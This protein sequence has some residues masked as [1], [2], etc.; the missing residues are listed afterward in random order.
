MAEK[1][2][3]DERRRLRS[4]AEEVVAHGAKEAATADQP[5]SGLM[6]ELQVQQVE[7]EMQ[8]EAL[9]GAQAALEV[10][11]DRYQDLYDFAPVGYLTVGMGGLIEEANLTCA[12]ML[13]EVRSNVVGR[14]FAA[15]VAPEDSDRWELA[16]RSIME[17]GG[18]QICDVKL[19]RKDGSPF[20]AALD[21]LRA[22]GSA[23]PAVRIALVDNGERERT[24]KVLRQGEAR[25][26]AGIEAS[27]VPSALNDELGNITWLNK[28]FLQTIGFTLRDIPTVADWWPLAYPD[29]GYR[30]SVADSWRARLEKAR[31]TGTPFPPMELQINCKDGKVRDFVVSASGLEGDFTGNH[32]VTLYE[33]TERKLAEEQRVVQEKRMD[34]AAEFGGMGLWDLDLT[35]NLAWRTLQHDRLFGYDELQPSWGVEEALHHVVPEDRPIFQHALEEALTT[36]DFHYELRIDPKNHPRRWIQADG[37]VSRDDAGRPV[38]MAGTVLDITERKRLEQGLKTEMANA[39]AIFESSPVAM[40]VVDETTNIVRANAASISMMGVEVSDIVQHRPGNALRCV[41]SSKDPRGCGYSKEC[42]L[43]QARNGIEA[44]IAG[45]GSMHGVEL[46]LELIRDGEP[47]KVWMEFGAQ[48]VVM[49]GRR[50][51]CVSLSDLTGRKQAEAALLVAHAQLALTSRLAALGTLVAGVAHEINNP[52]AAALSDQELARGAVRE[53]RDHLRGSG[54]LDRETEVRRLDE[55]VE[56][57]DEA[58]EAGRRIERIVKDLKTFGR[59]DQTRTRVRLIDIV[60]LAMRWLPVT[61][62]QTATVTVE[63]GGAPD[64]TASPGQIEQVVVN[65]VTNAAKATPEGKRGAIVVRIGPGHPGMARLDVVDHGKGIEPVVMARIFDPFFTTRDVGKGSGLG[66]SIC[67]TIVANHGGTLTATS[68]IGKGSTFRV[69]LPV[70]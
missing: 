12:S 64:I 36:G 3:T 8:N 34:L 13:G 35:T 39:D 25:L 57:L 4:H 17:K 14:S 54:P 40:I 49:N 2:V 44:L 21:C 70:A 66:L 67:H 33:I 1:P 28:A 32:I 46:Q 41:H 68:E 45:G 42:L 61:I 69:E 62:G 48:Q 31:L 60:E 55:V 43:C 51:L 7:L 29:P 53:V 63:N 23:G 37:R 18:K 38:R 26:R 15:F 59:H 27:P 9:R 52:L 20:G 30:E 22:K 58:Q 5:A 11:R 65:L 24:G 10:A 47:R 50:H 6:H 56:E 19:R 16:F